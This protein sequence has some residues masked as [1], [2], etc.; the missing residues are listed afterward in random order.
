MSNRSSTCECL[1]RAVKHPM[2]QVAPNLYAPDPVADG[3]PE[4]SLG[5]FVP[6]KVGGIYRFIPVMENFVRINRDILALIGMKNQFMTMYRLQK[7]GF[8]EM[9][10]VAPR[11]Y[12]LNLSS[13][14]N[15]VRR[16]AED[17]EFWTSANLKEYQ[18]VLL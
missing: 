18:K 2:I 13:W 16:C 15:H 5:K 8:I 9:V 17:D 14:Y 11:T 10:L 12:L 4:I 6:E 7:A 1:K 3:V